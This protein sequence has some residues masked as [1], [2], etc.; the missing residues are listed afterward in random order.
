MVI[1]CPVPTHIVARPVFLSFCSRTFKSVVIILV[2]EIPSGCPSATAPPL[3]FTLSGFQ[4]AFFI[5]YKA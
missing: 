2:P 1:P 4:F 3:R 5:Q